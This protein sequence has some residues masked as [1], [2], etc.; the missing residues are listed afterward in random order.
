MIITPELLRRIAPRAHDAD[1]WAPWLDH[2][3][4]LYEINPGNRLNMWLAQLAHE[5]DGFTRFEENLNYGVEGLL[6]TFKKYFP[7][8][9]IAERYARRPEAIASRVYANRMGNGPEE[10]GDG[11]KY[12]GRGPIQRTGKAAYR[13]DGGTLNYDLVNFPAKMAEPEIGAQAAG[14]YWFEHDCNG[15]A[16]QRNFRA[17]TKAINGGYNGLEDRQHRLQHIERIM[18]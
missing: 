18:S 14:L 1:E 10:S 11:W 13:H 8:R 17:I 16:D 7:D 15:W 9:A 12:R 3:A 5:S 2:A 6:E 4:R